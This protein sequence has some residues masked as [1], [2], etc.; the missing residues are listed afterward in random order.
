MDFFR[1]EYWIEDGSVTF[2]DGDVGDLNHEGIALQRAQGELSTLCGFDYDG[3]FEDFDEALVAAGEE[4][5][6]VGPKEG[7]W[8][9][10]QVI[11][12]LFKENGVEL[13]PHEDLI[14][15]ALDN[16]DA[17]EYAMVHWGWIWCKGTWFGM[18]KWNEDTKKSLISGINNILDENGFF[19]ETD[20][21]SYHKDRDGNE[22][23]DD[24]DLSPYDVEFT[25]QPRAGMS[26]TRESRTIYTTLRQLEG[27]E[28]GSGVP[29]VPAGP[30]AQLAK[31]DVEAQPGYYGAKMGDSITPQEFVRRLLG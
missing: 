19:N 2:A 28:A 20:E 6:F 4:A 24:G 30:N 3:A 9:Q 23:D 29:T 15:V 25:I 14:S 21:T 26:L 13:K 5:G 31:M 18:D 27:E 22:V 7:G 8:W 10:H 17:R 12:F 16:G 1:G 11:S